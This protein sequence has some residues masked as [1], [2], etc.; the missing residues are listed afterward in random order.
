MPALGTARGAAGFMEPCKICS[1]TGKVPRVRRRL[2]NGEPDR[3]DTID[4]PEVI[5]DVCQGSG[6]TA[7]ELASLEK[8]RSGN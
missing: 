7:V 4:W 2:P 6:E 1:G 3:F 5:C 8:T